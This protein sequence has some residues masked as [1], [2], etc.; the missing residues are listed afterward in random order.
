MAS[1]KK[2]A[3]R[4]IPGTD[5][6]TKSTTKL[7]LHFHIDVTQ[8]GQKVS[9]ILAAFRRQQQQAWQL[10]FYMR[11]KAAGTRGMGGGESNSHLLQ[12]DALGH[13]RATEGVGLH[14][15]N[16]V[17]L[18]VVLRDAKH[19]QNTIAK[20]RQ[21]KN[22]RFFSACRRGTKLDENGMWGEQDLRHDQSSE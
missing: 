22:T 12:D 20:N 8:D 6:H 18:V 13:G 2:H 7:Q 21:E 5:G 16:G 19:R 14:R 10:G 15:G 1:G 9:H 4:T 11:V 17:G 3:S